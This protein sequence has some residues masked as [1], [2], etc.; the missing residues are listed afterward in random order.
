MKL[1][2]HTLD[3][4]FDGT[5]SKAEDAD[6]R[7]LH[8]AYAFAEMVYGAKLNRVEQP[9]ILHAREVVRTL[10]ALDMDNDTLI[11]GMLYGIRPTDYHFD[12]LHKRFGA[13]ISTLIRNLHGLDI[14]T[15]EGLSENARTLETIR[16]ALLTATEVDIRVVLL[17]IAIAL[18]DL[19][20][21]LALQNEFRYRVAREVRNV[22]APLA[23]RLGLWA[24]K[25]ELEDKAFRILDPDS[26]HAI[27]MA[28]AE[29]RVDRQNRIEA[30]QTQ[31]AEMLDEVGITA[32]VTG[33]PKHIY[34]IH[35]KMVRKGVGLDEIYDAHALRVIVQP[36]EREGEAEPVL[37]STAQLDPGIVLCYQALGIVHNLWEPVPSEF[38]DYIQHPKPNG[39]R[40]LH[41]A[42]LLPDGNIM[43]VQ[44]RTAQMH[45]E[46]ERGIAAHWAYKEGHRTS[47]WLQK[48]VRSLRSALDAIQGATEEVTLGPAED[49]SEEI[50]AERVYVFTPNG[51]V[52]DLPRGSTPIDLAYAIHSGLGHRTRGAKVNGRM[53]SLTYKLKSGDRV[54]ILKHKNP[55]P[56]R[57]WM[58][59]SNYVVTTRARSR[60]R[61]WFRDNEREK[62]IEYGRAVV[63]REIKQRGLT[64]QIAVDDVALQLKSTDLDDFLA[65]VGFGDITTSQIEGALILIQ[66]ERRAAQLTTEAEGDDEALEQVFSAEHD[67]YRPQPKG[68]TVLGMGGLHTQF[69]QCCNPIP[70][71]PIVG[72][73][74]RGRGVTVHSEDC[75]EVKRLRDRGEDD[76]IM[77]ADWGINAGRYPV[78][79]SIR[80]YR[81]G[82][83]LEEIATVLKGQGITLLKTKS[84]MNGRFMNIIIRA[85]VATL[86][87]VQWVEQRIARLDNVI[88]VQSR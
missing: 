32:T 72:F 63:E 59:N 85:E 51:D 26:Y 54:E 30:A 65:H 69:A 48:R 49:V 67:T 19:R 60:I 88:E 61:K 22:Y 34:S 42:V 45:V 10:I 66:R 8:E 5:L 14:Y 6:T 29:R 50:L 37:E 68:L 31:L 81:S 64:Q 79:F 21:A 40:S 17:R 76:R 33:R 70:P 36:P 38:D 4:L 35:R 16:R 78:P 57:D 23:N 82:R 62:N 55:R 80:A 27:A 73:I 58:T 18:E 24:L 20:A 3:N 7:R 71:Q 47:P 46:G 87:Q 12:R 56:S 86:D 52:I 11:A 43:E 39:Y 74:T 2:H 1:S 9:Y 83:L 41:T 44:I 25:W 53:V 15:A 28:L 75:T 13:T 77:P 84:S